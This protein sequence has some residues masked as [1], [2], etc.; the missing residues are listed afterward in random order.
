MENTVHD[1]GGCAGCGAFCL[2]RF[3][4]TE[5]CTLEEEDTMRKIFLLLSDGRFNELG[6]YVPL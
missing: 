2:N 4:T 3:A 5:E 6:E 1:A